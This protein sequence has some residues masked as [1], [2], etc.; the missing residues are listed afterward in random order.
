MNPDDG[1]KDGGL[2][3]VALT[4][5]EENVK[6]TDGGVDGAG[7]TSFSTRSSEMVV[8]G[9]VLELSEEVGGG[10]EKLNLGKV[11]LLGR[12]AGGKSGSSATSSSGRLEEGL[13]ALS[14]FI[15]PPPEPVL[16]VVGV[17][18]KGYDKLL[19]LGRG[20]LEDSEIGGD[21]LTGVSLLVLSTTLFSP[22]GVSDG[23]N[24]IERLPDTEAA[25]GTTSF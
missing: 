10:E 11:K 22:P 18:D 7:R 6:G 16:L 9:V 3:A 21:C 13:M 4:I 5:G 8:S 24:D 25:A 1:E 23:L 19:V 12:E 17:L 15:L 14:L 2:A 20:A